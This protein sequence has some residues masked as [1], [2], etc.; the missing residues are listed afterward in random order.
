[1]EPE[2][3]PASPF[4]RR[5]PLASINALVEAQL[6]PAR[7]AGNAKPAVWNR[8]IAMYLAQRVGKWS[9][10][11]IGRFYND[12]DHSTVCYAIQRVRTLRETHP[13]VDELLTAFEEALQDRQL[14]ERVPIAWPAPLR[15]DK[16]RDEML[17]EQL[18]E[19]IAARLADRL[20][21]TGSL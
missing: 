8:Q 1:M 21:G 4:A 3:K 20:A 11:A 16:L 5:I 6:G 2:P 18:A 7:V 13:E 19:R 17:V 15:L 14:V 12:R 10:T 9:T